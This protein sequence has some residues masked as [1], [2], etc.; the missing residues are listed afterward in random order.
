MTAPIMFQRM[1]EKLFG[2]TSYL[3]VYIE[4]MDMGSKEMEEHLNHLE[5]LLNEFHKAD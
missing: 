1:P 3:K 5:R 4:N 2:D